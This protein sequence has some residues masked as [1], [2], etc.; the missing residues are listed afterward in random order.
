MANAV[1]QAAEDSGIDSYIFSTTLSPSDCKGSMLVSENGGDL[2]RSLKERKGK[3][4]CLMGG[5]VLT[6]SLFEAGVIDEVG[7]NIHP[8]LLGNGIPSF[9][10]TVG[11]TDLDLVE[12]RPLKNGCIYVLYDVRRS[13][14]SK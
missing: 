8:I 6:A 7:F 13:V 10:K 2:V 3:D 12:C 9:H 5:G 14:G 1:A 4:I 11:Q